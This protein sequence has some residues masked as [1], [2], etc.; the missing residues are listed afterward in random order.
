MNYSSVQNNDAYG[1]GGDTYDD[2]GHAP[3]VPAEPEEVW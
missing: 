3:S 2:V 1:G